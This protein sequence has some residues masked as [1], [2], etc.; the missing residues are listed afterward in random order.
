MKIYLFYLK[1]DK[2][3]YAYTSS[4][5]YR[6]EFLS[7][8]N[9]NCFT[10]KEVK[11]KGEEENIFV[12]TYKLKQLAYYP[13][14]TG[15]GKDDYVSI[16]ATAE[17]EVKIDSEIKHIEDDYDFV[18]SVMSKTKLKSKYVKSIK[19]ITKIYSNDRITIDV[20]SLFVDLFKDTF[21]DTTNE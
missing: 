13:Y 1:K 16:M 9:P 12:Y 18:R 4:K 15:L 10:L 11:L 7:Q 20:F 19:N 14:Q 5:A 8:R 21:I 6:D 2:S 17:E 3:L